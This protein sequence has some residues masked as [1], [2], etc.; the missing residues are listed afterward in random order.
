[1][2]VCVGVF[3][4]RGQFDAAGAGEGCVSAVTA[5]KDGV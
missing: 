4:C 5:G 1:M 3:D 2:G